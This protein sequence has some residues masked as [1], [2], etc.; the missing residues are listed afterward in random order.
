[1]LALGFP[2][3]PGSKS[4]TAA[5]AEGKALTEQPE[6]GTPGQRSAN[7][8]LCPEAEARNPCWPPAVDTATPFVRLRRQSNALPLRRRWKHTHSRQTVR[9]KR[10]WVSRARQCAVE[11]RRGRRLGPSEEKSLLSS[12]AA[13]GVFVSRPN[14]VFRETEAPAPGGSSSL[15]RPLPHP[16]R[17][18]PQGARP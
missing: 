1:M 9:I 13:P 17:H 4:H 12:K 11:I 2:G 3:D 5:G 15:L 7:R 6:A 16:L 18:T 10:R 14:L 8:S